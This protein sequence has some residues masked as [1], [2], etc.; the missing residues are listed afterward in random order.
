MN[1][2]GGYQIID[3][4]DFN[5]TS[6]NNEYD[7][8]LINEGSNEGSKFF[9]NIF[10]KDKKPLLISNIVI[11]GVEKNDVIITNYNI[12]NIGVKIQVNFFIYNYN[13]YI[14]NDSISCYFGITF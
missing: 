6:E 14:Y 5:F 12:A 8:E 10:G 7:I 1:K 11:N 3:L 2:K 4:K 13:A 9:N